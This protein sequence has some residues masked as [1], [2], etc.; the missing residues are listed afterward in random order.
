V[1]TV[2]VGGALILGILF[3]A[4]GALTGQGWARDSG[5]FLLGAFF[6]VTGLGIF[7]WPPVAVR[8]LAFPRPRRPTNWNEVGPAERTLWY[9]QG[10]MY[11]LVGGAII[12]AVVVL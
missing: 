12:F 3:S 5:N 11:A 8:W 9:A 6:L 7:L 1:A 2:A 10:I 4:V